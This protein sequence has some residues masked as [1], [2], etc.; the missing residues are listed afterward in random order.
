MFE[1][2]MGTYPDEEKVEHLVA[3]RWPYTP[4]T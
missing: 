2:K 4:L 3:A 1:L